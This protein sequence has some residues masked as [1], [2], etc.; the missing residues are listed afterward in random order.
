[1]KLGKFVPQKFGKFTLLDKIASGGMAEIRADAR[2]VETA[3][4]TS[5]QLSQE[6]KATF[7]Q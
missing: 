6:V 2:V 5:H 4:E 1:M 7:S 3:S